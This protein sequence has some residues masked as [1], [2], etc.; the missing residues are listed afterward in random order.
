MA[1]RKTWDEMSK[2]EKIIAA[3]IFAVI[4]VVVIAMFSGGSDTQTNQSQDNS[5]TTQQAQETEPVI[6][7]V[8]YTIVEE[9]DI[10][11]LDCSRVT[12]KIKVAD[13]ADPEAVK[14]TEQQIIDEKKSTWDDITVW[15]YNNSESD[16]FIKN[17]A[18]TVDM[19]EYST[20]E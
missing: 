16:E 19:A 15:T 5:T 6:E 8:E 20:C 12:Y 10:S 2:Q 17:N 4:M 18:F 11:F 7:P 14:A 1:E 9:K 3:V 13:D